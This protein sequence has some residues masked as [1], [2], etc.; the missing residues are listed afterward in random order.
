MAG[1]KAPQSSAELLPPL[2]HAFIRQ[3]YSK[4][5]PALPEML[6]VLTSVGAAECW[7]KKSTF[8][9]RRSASTYSARY[10]APAAAQIVMV[11]V[12]VCLLQHQTAAAVQ[13][14]QPPCKHAHASTT[15]AVKRPA[16]DCLCCMFPANSHT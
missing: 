15:T 11:K 10:V 2:V 7:H 8:K 4:V 3:E 5:D 12:L 9:A 16:A 14:L 6:E 1:V 13:L